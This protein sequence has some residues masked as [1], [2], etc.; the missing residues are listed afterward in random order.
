MEHTL[1]KLET[2]SSR[3][4]KLKQATCAIMASQLLTQEEKDQIDTVFRHLDT[5]CDGQIDR[6]DLKRGYREYFDTEVPEA[7]LDNIFDQ[8]NFSGS[9]VIEYSEFAIAILMAQ[10]TVD[11]QKL[12]AAFRVFD[13]DAKGYISAE[14]IKR[15]LKL[16]DEQDGYLRTKILRQVDAEE[17]GAID[18]EEFKTIM[19]S[20]SSLQKKKKKK[21][22]KRV[23]LKR[24]PRRSFVATFGGVDVTDLQLAT[25]LDGMDASEL[26]MH[27]SRGRSYRGA[28]LALEDLC[29]NED[30]DLTSE[31]ETR[32]GTI[33]ADCSQSSQDE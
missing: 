2:F 27:S 23:S 8:V 18:F 3:H 29:E 31:R 5:S 33:L 7:E 26:S 6:G 16:G 28:D 25:V 1:K 24:S 22:K 4:S 9:G 19:H 11:N 20:T 10:N 12:K 30:E 13:E 32:R 21:K 14:D 15:V 17:T